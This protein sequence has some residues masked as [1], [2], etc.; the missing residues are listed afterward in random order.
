[1]I[2]PRELPLDLILMML[3]LFNLL[4]WMSPRDKNYDPE[5]WKRINRFF[6]GDDYI[7][8]E[9]RERES[10][11]DIFEKLT[12]RSVWDWFMIKFGGRK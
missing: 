5:F 6:L 9:A 11:E 7:E 4:N 2:D 1:M 3:I 12:P 10:F 8:R